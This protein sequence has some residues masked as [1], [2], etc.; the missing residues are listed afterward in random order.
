MN[1][2]KVDN[3]EKRLCLALA[4]GIFLP[5]IKFC[6]VQSI[7]GWVSYNNILNI[8]LGGVFAVIFLSNL[9]MI[10]RRSGIF[11]LFTAV[12]LVLIFLS[13]SIFGEPNLSNFK[14]AMVDIALLSCVLFLTA[15]SVRDYNLLFCT[16]LKWAP[17]V[18]V[19]S[20]F[21]VVCTAVIGV[22]GVASTTYNMS[23]SYYV[24]IPSLLVFL[25][26]QEKKRVIHLILFLIGVF[27]VLAMGSR[28]PMLCLFL[29]VFLYMLK[30]IK[31]S[32]KNTALLFLSAMV[33][34][35][36]V[37][38]FDQL[39][40]KLY[41]WLLLRGIESRTL[42]K[43]IQGSLLDDSNRGEIIKASMDTIAENWFG[44]GFMGDLSA[45]NIII[46]NLLWFGIV[47][48]MLLNII[49]FFIVVRT[50][51]LKANIN[52]KHRLLILVFFCYAI[53]DAF[54]NL[55]IWGKDMFWI[56]LG[57]LFMLNRNHSINSNHNRNG[58]FQS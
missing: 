9:S 27:V 43:I 30:T 39:A 21:M 12:T 25:G 8:L 37:L 51:F 53:P 38:N 4:L 32:I 56:Y 47:L 44:I 3:G 23:L 34:P 5:A 24:L 48:G 18:I 11:V 50:L 33:A 36:I 42:L 46:E 52:D 54:L 49:L 28:G 7:P 19:A 13:A 35:V 22:V 15:V 55:T 57:L 16:L 10:L 20:V 14:N 45:H 31:L 6:I 40:T 41:D 2:E 29:F 1:R 17:M 58:R 26:Y